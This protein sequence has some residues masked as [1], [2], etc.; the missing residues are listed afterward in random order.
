MKTGALMYGN[1]VIVSGK[2]FPHLGMIKKQL[3]QQGY[4]SQ[5]FHSH[6]E[7]NTNLRMQHS[8]NIPSSVSHKANNTNNQIKQIPET[9][10]VPEKGFKEYALTD[11]RSPDW[12]NSYIAKMGEEKF[13]EYKRNLYRLLSGLK[14][15]ESIRIESWCKPV[16]IDLFMKIASCYVQ[17]SRGTYFFTNNYTLIT[18][19]SDAKEMERTYQIFRNKCREEEPGADGE[20]TEGGEGGTSTVSALQPQVQ[21]KPEG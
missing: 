16:N 6:Y 20:R 18:H 1:A 19:Y 13:W 11:F 5:L 12:M 4:S 14:V 17:E 8:N 15:D 9:G 3:I 10:F 2:P 21:G 7:H